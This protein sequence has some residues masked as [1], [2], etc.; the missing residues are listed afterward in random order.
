MIG[1]K[2]IC[3]TYAH[4]RKKAPGSTTACVHNNELLAAMQL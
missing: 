3:I 2:S 4:L 1:F